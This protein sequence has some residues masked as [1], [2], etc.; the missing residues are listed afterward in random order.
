MNKH[1]KDHLLDNLAEIY[2]SGHFLADMKDA[3]PEL[4]CES[5]GAIRPTKNQ[6]ELE[7]KARRMI[8][9]VSDELAKIAGLNGNDLVT[10]GKNGVKSLDDLADLAADE[11]LEIVG[12]E[13]LTEKTAGE[14]IMAARAHW[15]TQAD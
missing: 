11:L 8:W 3:S 14:I 6:I 4:S 9:G 13:T 1:C 10:L 2:A 7:L 15:F 5:T 12:T